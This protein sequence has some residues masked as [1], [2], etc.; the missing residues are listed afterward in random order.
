MKQRPLRVFLYCLGIPLLCVLAASKQNASAQESRLRSGT[1]QPHPV[2]L[3]FEQG[4]VGQA[5]VGWDSPT[6]INYE[7]ELT[8]EKPKSGRRAAL[9][10][11]G[12]GAAADGPE[13]GNLMQ[14]FEA[15]PFRGSRVR[16]RGAVRVE[17]SEQRAHA[18]LWMRVDRDKD[19]IGFFGNTGR[20]PTVS[21]E[22]QYFEIIGDVEED[23][24]VIN[25][26]MIL[27]GKGKAWL[28]DVSFE[29][30]GK[31]IALAEPARPLT[32][33]GLENL[34]AFTHLLGY[35]RHFHP[36]DE[37][38]ATDWDTFAVKGVQLVEDAKNTADLAHKLETIF[39]P[40]APTVRVF[41]TG[42]R[43]R[44]PSEVE[45]PRNESSLKVISWRH[46]GFG[47]STAQDSLYKSERVSKDAPRGIVS[48]GSPTPQKPFITSLGA[49]IS[50]L[51][52][53][54]LF[55]DAKGTLPHFAVRTGD[56]KAVL[57]KYSGNDRAT[58]LADVALAWN[59]FQHFYPYFD[60]VQT[61]WQQALGAALK[62]AANDLDERA[63][64]RTLRRMVA[65]LR[66]GH[67]GVY[68]PSDMGAYTTAAIFGWIEGRLV[69]THVAAEGAEGLQPGDIVL[70]VDGKPSLEVLTEEEVL[71]SGASPQWRR[72]VALDV[73]SEGS[74][75]SQIR[76]DV[77]TQSGQSRSVL[78]R[79]SVEA[80]T[81]REERPP[82]VHE[83]RLG[84]FYLD[85]CR[86]ND[87][88]FQGILPRLEK[89]NGVIFDL[90]GYPRVSPVV[91][92]HLIDKPVNSARWNVP[93]ITAPDH[94]D[95]VEYDTGGRWTLEPKEPRLK[96]KI[97]F[98]TD[99]RA[100]SYAE[101]Y[102][103]II[104]AYKLAEIVGEP[105]AGTNGDINPF[106]LPGNYRVVWTGM[107][108]LKHDGSQHHGVGIQP[109][110]PVSRTIRGIAEKRDEQLERAIAIVSQ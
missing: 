70:K 26:G 107:K 28:D 22:W 29:E 8:E 6:K 49:G 86:I 90:R 20:P 64:L 93:I 50:C 1:V 11:S 75:D 32:N 45:L 34:V 100:I 85:L 41:L 43:P 35:V 91:I 16:F 104:E 52:P 31:V 71:I 36:S 47:Q 10:R 9:L 83:I 80:Q 58:R 7:V 72:A 2:N 25:I 78:L 39:Q 82:K 17:A 68:H 18:Q 110:V 59:I 98:L 92:S 53:V 84:I 57:V 97:A 33:R 99:G 56:S 101:S 106:T 88:D 102:M 61:D 55:A 44:L 48:E 96:A 30:L 13:F 14:A 103:G 12:S 19:K 74:K 79:R 24:V 108:V 21:N 4:P 23:A 77:Q 89:A 73:L 95:T 67:G 51:V 54:A 66:D 5:P 27:S 105:T 62:A 40:I 76:L 65:L 87:K 46:K 42:E 3:D 69:I 15:T 94:T 81:L 109:T 38:A 60:V 63:F 37:A